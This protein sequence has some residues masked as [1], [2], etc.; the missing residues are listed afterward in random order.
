M[1]KAWI[2]DLWVK[3]ADLSLPDGSNARVSPTPAQLKALTRLPEHFRTTRFGTGKRWRVTWHEDVGG[4]QKPR[5]RA[6]DRRTGPNGAEAFEAS[7]DEDIRV[8]RYMD[9]SSAERKFR[10]VAEAWIEAKRLIE[11]TSYIEY[12]GKLDRYV[13]PKWGSIQIGQIQRSDV[14]AWVSELELG[15]APR[16][17]KNKAAPKPLGHSSITSIVRTVFGGVINYAIGER[18]LSESPLERVELPK[19]P[20]RTRRTT[21]THQEVED[22]AKACQKASGEYRDYVLIHLLGYSAPRINE[23]LALQKH[24]LN[25]DLGRAEIEQTWKNKKGGGRTLGAPKNGEQRSIPIVD[26]L[27]PML[28]TL[29][30]E[31]AEDGWVFRQKH[32]DNAPWSHNWLNRVWNPAL[33]ALKYK[34]RITPHTLRHTAITFAIAAG[35]DIKVV[36]AMAGHRTADMT[37][38]VYGH[39]F[40]DKLEDV[41]RLMADHR[42]ASVKPALRAIG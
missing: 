41:R 22:L 3:D 5:S 18:W 23:A 13:L 37:L 12:R 32:V 16:H 26:H 10:D 8:G 25:L 30:K 36:Q 35:A 19:A 20:M 38:N 39:L 2:V 9:P 29:T 42:A 33:E 21:L 27:I 15:T 34:T 24:H 4:E 11:D 31:R 7:M 1:A 17:F 28:R 40:P 14:D 6:F